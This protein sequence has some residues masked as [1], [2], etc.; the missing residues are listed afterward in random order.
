M[1]FKPALEAGLAKPHGSLHLRRRFLP[2][3]L[4]QPPARDHRNPCPVPCAPL[5]PLNFPLTCP[6]RPI[7]RFLLLQ[8]VVLSLLLLHGGEPLDERRVA[9]VVRGVHPVRP[10]R[11]QVLE[12]DL[13]EAALEAGLAEVDGVAVG[14]E[15]G[16][17]GVES[18]EEGEGLVDGS[19][20]GAEEEEELDDGGA[21]GAVEPEGGEKVGGGEALAEK[22]EGRAHVALSD[23]QVHDSVVQRPVPELVAEN[24][25][26]L[27][28]LD[29]SEESVIEN[30]ALVLAEAELRGGKKK[31]RKREA[32]GM[33]KGTRLEG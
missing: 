33:K 25:E 14:G 19:P 2:S 7:S 5:P 26:K 20:D 21:G 3:P 8:Q 30:D 9:V 12:A 18:D 15:L 32:E 1:C 22:E 6:E 24:R 23:E 10:H 16:G 13:G 17:P 11:S 31:G 29:L 27:L 28:G 4:S